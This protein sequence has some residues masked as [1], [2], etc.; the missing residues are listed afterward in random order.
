MHQEDEINTARESIEQARAEHKRMRDDPHGAHMH[1][2]MTRDRQIPAHVGEGRRR[3]KLPGKRAR[4]LRALQAA[5]QQLRGLPGAMPSRTTRAKKGHLA[6]GWQEQG[7]QKLVT[8]AIALGVLITGKTPEAV[9]KPG[10]G[11]FRT[12][13]ALSAAVEQARAAGVVGDEVA[14]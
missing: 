11:Q 12:W 3:R 13:K 9:G 10:V 7:R 1:V 8:D 14:Q 2:K 6:I 5:K 4:M